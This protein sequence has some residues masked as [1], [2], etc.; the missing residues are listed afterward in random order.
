MKTMHSTLPALMAAA[1]L[2]G[3][4]AARAQPAPESVCGAPL[5][6]RD[7]GLNE[8]CTRVQV[9]VKNLYGIERNDFMLL[10]H[11]KPKGDGPF[12][13]VVMNH[14]RG[15]DRA[16][17]ARVRYT[18]IARYW[19]QRGFAVFVPT[20]LSYGATG[21]TPDTE[22]SGACSNKNYRPMMDAASE[23]VRSAIAFGKSLPWVDTQRVLVMGQSVGG[24]T[25]VAVSGKNYPGV[26]AAINF[27]G[28]SGGDPVG[29][30]EDPCQPH[31]IGDTMAHFAKTAAVPMLWLYAPNDKFWGEKHPKQWFEHYNAAGGK[32]QFVALPQV[33]AARDDGHGAISRTAAF[34][35]PK[36]DA[37]IRQLG[38]NFQAD[39]PLPTADALPASMIAAQKEVYQRFLAAGLPRAVAFAPNGAAGWATGD[40]F[41]GAE[42]N[43]ADR[44][45][46]HCQARGANS[47]TVF[48]IDRTIID[49]PP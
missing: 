24:F 15:P 10:T 1:L 43:A 42:S 36:L 47:C 34:W 20:R 32:A 4:H 22:D 8:A 11:Y 26:L 6:A 23:Q 39:R 41:N 38:F 7:A 14:G 3:S 35:E 37:F 46:A 44:A 17:P 13:L 40:H 12:P 30:P 29:R 28:G 45:L 25:S 9:S 5:Q 18:G 33:G 27:A 48:A 19:V 31:K 16:N 2:M 21:L 49:T